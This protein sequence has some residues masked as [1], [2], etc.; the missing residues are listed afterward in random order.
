M[1]MNPNSRESVWAISKASI[2][3]F[4]DG[5]TAG[6][7]EG[8]K[9]V[10]V[11]G[12]VDALCVSISGTVWS[13]IHD[14]IHYRSGVTPNNEAGT[15]W[16]QVDQE[17]SASLLEAGGSCLWAYARSNLLYVRTGM[18]FH[19][20]SSNVTRIGDGWRHIPTPTTPSGVSDLAM[21]AQD[22][23]YALTDD[24]KLFKREGCTQSCHEGV[25]WV[26][27][28][29]PKT[30]SSGFLG[31]GA[32]PRV[33]Q[34]AGGLEYLW[35]VTDSHEVW[36]APYPSMITEISW[37]RIPGQ[38]MVFVSPSMCDKEITWGINNR[39]QIFVRTS[40][41]VGR[42]EWLRQGTI[43][44]RSLTVGVML[45]YVLPAE[46]PRRALARMQS[47]NRVR[48]EGPAQTGGAFPDV[49]VAT[50]RD[51]LKVTDIPFKM[52]QCDTMSTE[53]LNALVIPV[54]SKEEVLQ[55]F[56]YDFTTENTVL[57]EVM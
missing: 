57:S 31:L 8:E 53:L 40:P 49:V 1:K 55:R 27:V 21:T 23:L 14:K 25:N 3:F 33:K 52:E 42:Y 24:N 38:K 6:K 18:G 37:E 54:L 35:A 22:D 4:R 9:W 28:A 11:D 17:F 10:Q 45:N 51:E 44:F 47:M 32:V 39:D 43:M 29:L 19:S 12:L 13:L 26:K 2:P 56:T 41:Q 30:G 46:Q 20:N 48:G 50:L 36:R 16:N 34:I 7:E 5:I 15:A